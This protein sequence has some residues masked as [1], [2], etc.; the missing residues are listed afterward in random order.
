MAERHIEDTL[1]RSDF[2]MPT[3]LLCS[4]AGP[5]HCHRRLICDY[6][7]TRWPDVHAIHL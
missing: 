5:G 1:T 2:D 7:A 4:E 6:L 3:A